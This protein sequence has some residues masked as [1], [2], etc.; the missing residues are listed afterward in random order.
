M[1]ADV[2]GHDVDHS[3]KPHP[4][5]SIVFGSNGGEHAQMV[6]EAIFSA[7]ERA[8]DDGVVFC[9]TGSVSNQRRL[10]SIDVYKLTFLIFFM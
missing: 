1:I 5:W 2:D 4:L 7:P 8:R 3:R 6:P 10:K 9:K